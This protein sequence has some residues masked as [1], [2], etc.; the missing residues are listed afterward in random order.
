MR[1]EGVG[2]YC[3]G[4]S[5]EGERLRAASDPARA[6]SSG[7]SAAQSPVRRRL[8]KMNNTCEQTLFHL[9]IGQDEVPEFFIDLPTVSEGRRTLES[10]HRQRAPR[11]TTA[12]TLCARVGERARARHAHCSPLAA[13]AAVRA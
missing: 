9:G 13:H 5:V 4:L 6:L 7:A 8:V 3:R 1:H 10:N 11:R 2:G 12:P